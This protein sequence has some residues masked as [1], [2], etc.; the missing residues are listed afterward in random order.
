MSSALT[1]LS[2]LLKKTSN[3]LFS[4][5]GSG[6]EQPAKRNTRTR[7]KEKNVLGGV[8]HIKN[9]SVNVYVVFNLD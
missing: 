1:A 2:G 9:Y 7:N 4:G 6:E 5:C 3:C 8:S